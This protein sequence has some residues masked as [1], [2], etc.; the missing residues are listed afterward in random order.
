[1]TIENYTAG[2]QVR[3]DYA[4]M[5]YWYQKEPSSDFFTSPT[6]EQRKP[7]PGRSYDS[8]EIEWLVSKL[9]AGASFVENE[10]LSFD[11]AV[12][13]V[14]LGR[15]FEFDVEFDQDGLYTIIPMPAPGSGADA[16]E[17]IIGGKP[18]AENKFRM[19]KGYSKVGVRLNKERVV[20]DFF[21]IERLG[22]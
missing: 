17:L 12:E 21:R 7:F 6:L 22:D 1:M 18:V 8:V 5:A 11:K 3:N 14:G 20:M 9:P 13:F 2:Q 4:S 15:V 19:K 16:V 10:R